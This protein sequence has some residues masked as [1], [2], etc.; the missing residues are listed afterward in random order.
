[1]LMHGMN[2][3]R[4]ITDRA[5]YFGLRPAIIEQSSLHFGRC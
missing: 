4:G 1:M 5:L 2:K 3:R